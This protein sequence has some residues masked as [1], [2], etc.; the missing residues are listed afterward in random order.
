MLRP[1]PFG[2]LLHPCGSLPTAVTEVTQAFAKMTP[3]PFSIASTQAV[4]TEELLRPPRF[5]GEG[6]QRPAAHGSTALESLGNGHPPAAMF[7]KCIS[8]DHHKAGRGPQGPPWASLEPTPL[9][10]FHSGSTHAQTA[11]A[12]GCSRHAVLCPPFD[13]EAAWTCTTAC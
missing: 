5:Q 4:V 12:D 7:G 9:R 10:F 11:S 2:S 8:S 13:L 3:E 1:D 6:N